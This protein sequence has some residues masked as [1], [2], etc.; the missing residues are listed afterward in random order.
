MC[1][2]KKCCWINSEDARFEPLSV[3]KFLRKDNGVIFD[4]VPDGFV[5][6]VDDCLERVAQLDIFQRWIDPQHDRVYVQWL[7]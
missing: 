3:G 7:R 2:F 6:G 1:V 4:R 5:G